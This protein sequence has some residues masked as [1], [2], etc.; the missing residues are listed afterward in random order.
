MARLM[1]GDVAGADSVAKQ[2]SGE[3]ASSAEW[4]WVSGR[5]KE[6]YTKLAAQAAGLRIAICRRELM[7]TRGLG[8]AAE[9]TA[10]RGAEMAQ[11]AARQATPANGRS[12]GR[13]AVRDAAA[14]DSGRMAG[15]RRA[16][17]S[18]TRRRIR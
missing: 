2:G 3:L 18:R 11:K 16:G 17:R 6:A 1:T 4:L 15:A 12:G 8:D 13:G 14:G 10:T 9:Q 5:R 7:P